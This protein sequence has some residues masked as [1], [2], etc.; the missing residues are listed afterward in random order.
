MVLVEGSLLATVIPFLLMV[1]A[2]FGDIEMLNRP[3]ASK[4][5]KQAAPEDIE[6]AA[7]VWRR[8]EVDRSGRRSAGRS[9]V[10]IGMRARGVEEGE[11]QHLQ[12]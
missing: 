3:S 10:C 7:G 8:Y 6:R 2:L 1:V 11:D 4:Y 5:R 9:E 12:R